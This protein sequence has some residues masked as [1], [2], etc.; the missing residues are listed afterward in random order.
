MITKRIHTEPTA[1]MTPS[2]VAQAL[3]VSR[4][5]ITRLAGRGELPP[6]RIGH[7]LRF[8]RADVDELIR[9]G[10]VQLEALHVAP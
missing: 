6:V 1:L 2:E 3:A 9:R 8:H 5:T 4:S 10:S 7:A